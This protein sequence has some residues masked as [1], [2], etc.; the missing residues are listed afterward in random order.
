MM[1]DYAKGILHKASLPKTASVRA[2]LG[3]ACQERKKPH[4]TWCSSVSGR[5]RK[6]TTSIRHRGPS[7]SPR[8]LPQDGEFCPPPS[9]DSSKCTTQ[10]PLFVQ[11]VSSLGHARSAA[12]TRIT[13]FPPLNMI[14]DDCFSLHRSVTP[15]RRFRTLRA[16]ARGALTCVSASRTPARP[17]R[18]STV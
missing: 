6:A 2:R 7:T 10:S 4:Q 5:R 18:P 17:L 3:P 11:F 14:T 13:T 9:S 15:P 8:Q 1:D 12:S 16:P